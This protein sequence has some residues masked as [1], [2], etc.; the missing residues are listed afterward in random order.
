M[1]TGIEADSLEVQGVFSVLI[2]AL[3]PDFAHRMATVLEELVDE[4]V[5]QLVIREAAEHVRSHPNQ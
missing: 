2:N 5:I 4:Q 3:P 1:R